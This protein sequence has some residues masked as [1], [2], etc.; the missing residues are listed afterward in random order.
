MIVTEFLKV[1]PVYP[2]EEGPCN[3]PL[4]LLYILITPHHAAQRVIRSYRRNQQKHVETPHRQ[5]TESNTLYDYELYL[6]DWH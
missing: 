2:L 3:S 4:N 6:M 1:L 5:T